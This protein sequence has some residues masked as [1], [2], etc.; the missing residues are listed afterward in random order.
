MFQNIGGVFDIAIVLCH[1]GNFLII[2]VIIF[3]FL[4]YESDKQVITISSPCVQ[5][6][7]GLFSLL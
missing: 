7:I 1:L 5:H 3:L 4:F 6:R 2:I